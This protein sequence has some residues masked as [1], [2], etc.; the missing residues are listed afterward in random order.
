[1]HHLWRLAI[2]PL[3]VSTA[4]ADPLVYCDESPGALVFS[5][6]F[7]LTPLPED[8]AIEYVTDPAAFAAAGWPCGVPLLFQQWEGERPGGGGPGRSCNG[9]TVPPGKDAHVMGDVS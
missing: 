9:A 6:G 7:L 2:L 4:L 3:V 1:M 8:Q 5:E